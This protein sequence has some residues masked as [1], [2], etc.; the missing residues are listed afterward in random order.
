MADGFNHARAMRVAEIMSDFRTLHRHIASVRLTYAPEDH[1][2]EG[3]VV[4]RQCVAEAQ[5]VLNQPFSSSA[6]HPRGDEEQEK[7]QLRQILMDASLRRFKVQKIY[8]RASAAQRWITARNAIL[9]GQRPQIHHMAALQQ[10]TR[11]LR[12]ELGSITDARVEL[13]LRSSDA[14]QNKWLAEDPSL[15]VISQMLRPR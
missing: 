8:M 2:L 15:A 5:S 4:M 7:S 9:K 13:T 12:S 11:T 10:I 3:F 14:A 6:V 1:N